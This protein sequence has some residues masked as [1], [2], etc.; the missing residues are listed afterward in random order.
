MSDVPVTAAWMLCFLLVIRTRLSFEAGVVCA[1][2]VLIRP[3]L[4]PLAVIPLLI[5]PKKL[6]FAAPVIAAGLFL[7]FMQNL[8]YGSPLRSG[9]GTA[10]ELFAITNVVPNAGRY[11]NW[12]VATAPVLLLAPF[13]FVRLKNNPH[14]RAVMAFALLVIAAYLVYAVFDHWSYLRFL[15]PAMAVFAIFA[16]IELAAWI[17]RRPIAIRFPIFFVLMLGIVSHGLFVA[18]SFE[19]FKLKD[20]LRRV[21]QVADAINHTAPPNAVIIAGEQSGS[22][23]YYTGRSIL[24]WEAGTP[25]TFPK[26][27]ETLL[28]SERPIYIVL[29][30]WEMELFRAKFPNLGPAELDWPPMLEAGSSHRTLA[31]NLADRWRFQLGQRINTVRIQ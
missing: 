11:F 21:E 7:G 3:N 22:M 8:W 9:Y 19:V 30:A 10:D 23:R 17:E 12:L 6:S 26:A 25:D 15:L 16:G 24:R 4:A 18:R 28:K 13:A 1:L 20:Q 2:A 31:W 29:D 27:V 5:A 14:A